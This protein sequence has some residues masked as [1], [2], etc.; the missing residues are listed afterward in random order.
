MYLFMFS[1]LWFT[2]WNESLSIRCDLVLEPR[3]SHSNRFDSDWTLPNHFGL[4]WFCKD[5]QKQQSIF[6]WQLMRSLTVTYYK[7]YV[8]LKLK[9]TVSSNVFFVFKKVCKYSLLL[10]FLGAQRH[11]FNLTKSDVEKHQILEI[12]VI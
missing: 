12:V 6:W 5:F 1:I 3:I 4:I 10:N 2:E 7:N 9:S 8:Q 11:E